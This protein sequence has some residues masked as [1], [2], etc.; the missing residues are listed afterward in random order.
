MIFLNFLNGC[1]F[2]RFLFVLSKKHKKQK[3]SESSSSEDDEMMKMISEAAVE[4]N[5]VLAT[6]CISGHKNLI[7][8]KLNKVS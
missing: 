6:S 8:S 5:A 2:Q 4:P 3:G 1:F 7:D